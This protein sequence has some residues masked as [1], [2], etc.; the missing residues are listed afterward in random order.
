MQ[1]WRLINQGQNVSIDRFFEMIPENPAPSTSAAASSM[2][3]SSNAGQQ[4]QLN[5]TNHTSIVTELASLDLDDINE[6]AS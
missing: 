6:E 2:I 4:Q 5:N 3:S 1:Q